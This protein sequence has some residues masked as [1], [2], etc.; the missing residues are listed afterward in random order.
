MMIALVEH[1]DAAASWIYQPANDLM[2][3]A[4]RNGGATRNGKS[5]QLTA[6]AKCTNELRGDVLTRFLPEETKQS[7]AEN[8]SKFGFVGAGTKSAGID[9]PTLLDGSRDFI[10]YW[11]LLPWDHTPGVLLLEAA[12][13]CVVRPNGKRYAGSMTDQGLIIG[14]SELVVAQV[15]RSLLGLP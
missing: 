7:V 5:I 10:V 3:V 13:G 14:T 4:I 2:Y 9:Y 11:R 12:G 6:T 8:Q 15:R 1:G